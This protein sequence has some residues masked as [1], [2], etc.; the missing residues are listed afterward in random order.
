M[1]MSEKDKYVLVDYL[2]AANSGHAD[3]LIMQKTI[4]VIAQTLLDMESANAGQLIGADRL[5]EL[6]K[7][8]HADK[9]KK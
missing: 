6:S 1:T 4:A 2:K 9:A 8:E 5:L 7:R 3:S